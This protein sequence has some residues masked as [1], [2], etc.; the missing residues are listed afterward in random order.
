MNY[1]LNYEVL[2]RIARVTLYVVDTNLTKTPEELE[3]TASHLKMEFEMKDLRKLIYA[4]TWS[5]SIVL[6]VFWSTCRTTPLRFHLW[7]YPWS[8]IRY[9]QTRPLKRL[10][11]PKFHLS[12][13]LGFVVFSSL[14]LDKIS[15]SMLILVKMQLRAYTQPLNW[16]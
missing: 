12:S 6:T 14:Y 5:W 11:N 13:T 16:Y 7:V 8:S 9:M 1:A 3:K 10:W 15:H 4:L 2:F